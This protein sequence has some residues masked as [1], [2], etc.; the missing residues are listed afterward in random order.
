MHLVYIMYR[1]LGRKLV[2]DYIPIPTPSPRL[3]LLLD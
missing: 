2:Y 3:N 1:V